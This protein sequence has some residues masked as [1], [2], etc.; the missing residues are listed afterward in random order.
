[1]EGASHPDGRVV[2]GGQGVRKTSWRRR[3]LSW[4][5]VDKGVLLGE[6]LREAFQA[7]GAASGFGVPLTACWWLS[8]Q[9]K[10]KR[11]VRGPGPRSRPGWR[12]PAPQEVLSLGLDAGPVGGEPGGA[13]LCL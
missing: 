13:C 3:V 12:G 5:L 9:T 10:P 8:H 4:A 11:A 6:E 7:E 2:V 1:M